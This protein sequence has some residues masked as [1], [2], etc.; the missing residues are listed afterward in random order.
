MTATF[1]PSPL[2]ARTAGLVLAGGRSRRFGSEKAVAQLHGR[3]LMDWV[4]DKLASFPVFAVSTAPDA[5]AAQRAMTI[6]AA[7]LFDDPSL[8]QGPLNGVHAGL[9]WACALG[10]DFLATAPCDAPL[11]TGAVYPA[12]IDGIGE[13]DACFAV[14]GT[15]EHPLCAVWRTNVAATL[16]DILAQG[17]HPPVRSVLAQLGARRVGFDDARGFANANTREALVELERRR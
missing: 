17:Q 12:L 11:M 7:V 14:V 16:R 6:G 2:V 1:N 3:A 13:A 9:V 10:L 5:A 8:P 15:D 4:A